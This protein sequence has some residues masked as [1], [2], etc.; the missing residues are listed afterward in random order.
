MVFKDNIASSNLSRVFN[1]IYQEE[2]VAKQDISIALEMSLPTVTQN[3]KTLEE[4]KLITTAGE[5]ESKGGRKAKAITYVR[6]SKYALGLDITNQ[7]IGIVLIN[8]AG[9]IIE[10]TRYKKP[11]KR[12]HKYLQG[13]GDLIDDFILNHKVPKKKILGVGVS[14]PG[15]L[16]A[17]G[18]KIVYLHTL[19]VSNMDC[20]E[21]S[22]FISYPS[23][24]CHAANAGSI[25][26]MWKRE[27][28]SNIAYF[29][30]H[31]NVGGSIIINNQLYLGNNQRSSEFGHMTL[32]RNGKPCYC[33]KKGCMDA[34]CAANLLTSKELGTTS[35]EDFFA[36]LN[37]GDEKCRVFWDEYLNYLAIAVNNIRMALDCDVILGSY[38]GSYMDDYIQ[39]LREKVSKLNPFEENSQ[40]VKPCSYKI[41]ASAVGA[42]LLTV[43]SFINGL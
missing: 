16:D 5:F 26:E 11:F 25:A 18:N 38:I 4:K 28:E 1:F 10:H 36:K 15:I 6:D 22:Q 33:G 27:V 9:E 24:F 30:L 31:N 7:H 8:I 3:L 21:F 35:L 19:G 29:F 41:E 34:Y 2:K 39:I 14:V 17:T 43:E 12:S 23:I 42:A 32:V 20:S 37:Q 40:Y 13:I